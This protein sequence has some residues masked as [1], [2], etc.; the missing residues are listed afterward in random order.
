MAMP[1]NRVEREAI[2]DS[3][4]KIESIQSSLEQVEGGKIPEVEEIQAC[5][6]LTDRRLRSVLRDRAR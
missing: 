4:L 3:V 6:K 1:L 2:T 5:L